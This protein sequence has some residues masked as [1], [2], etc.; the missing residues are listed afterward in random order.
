[1]L[2]YILQRVSYALVTL[3]VIATLTF[4]L[5]QVM[6]GDPFRD[7]KMSPEIRRQLR[8]AYGL[9]KPVI[10]QYGIYMTNLLQGDLGTS[11]KYQGRK[12]Q[13]IIKASFP[14]SFSIGWRALVFA[15]SFGLVFGIIAALNHEKVWDY[16]V[17]FIA[18]VGVSVPS[19]VMGPLLAYVFGVNLGWLPVTVDETQISMILPSLALGLGTLAFVSRMMRTTTLEVLRQDYIQT[20]KAKGLS[21][22]QIV[23]RH[24]IRNAIMPVV[25]ILGP[26]CASIITGSI[27]VEKVFAVAGLGEYF[28]TTILEADYPMIMGITIFY[29]VLI[30]L[31]ML[32]VDIAYGIID[33]K[34]RATAAKGR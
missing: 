24:I 8:K 18:I 11:I 14:K 16:A 9:D 32:A 31:S 34:M 2:K 26:L 19:I 25:T 3:W 21:R 12:V 5:M 13:N 28:T 6:P 1:M 22:S 4:V 20:A 30:I 15:V 33:P 23:R 10:E 17:I 27:V 7:E 29:A